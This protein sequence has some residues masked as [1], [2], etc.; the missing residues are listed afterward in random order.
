MLK[1]GGYSF[2]SFSKTSKQNEKKFFDGETSTNQ[3]ADSFISNNTQT[4]AKEISF[5]AIFSPVKSCA[6]PDL[7]NEFKGFFVEYSI[8]PEKKQKIK[9]RRLLSLQELTRRI[10]YSNE[11]K[12][13]N[14]LKISALPKH[15]IKTLNRN[16]CLKPFYDFM[17]QTSSSSY[18][19]NLLHRS[20]ITIMTKDNTK[21]KTLLQKLYL[22]PILT[23]KERGAVALAFKTKTGTEI[24]DSLETLDST[25]LSDGFKY[26]FKTKIMGLNRL[27]RSIDESNK[28]KNSNGLKISIQ[29]KHIIK[30]LT[31]NDDLKSFYNFMSQTFDNN[32]RE[33]ILYHSLMTIMGK[34]KPQAEVLLQNLYSS[35]KLTEEEKRIV[36]ISLKIKTGEDTKKAD[37]LGVFDPAPQVEVQT[38]MGKKIFT[39]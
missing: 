23:E 19:E 34:D 24:E 32:Y 16:D 29:P 13:S 20:L 36:A 15:I 28:F 9:K 10:D 26:L 5:K 11:S 4:K 14:E 8:I 31:D 33:N 38:K 3:N 25:I 1:V 21:A 22:F 37:D 17:S 35:Q 27:T 18:G 12:S 7:L 30:E 39:I 2:V 6:K